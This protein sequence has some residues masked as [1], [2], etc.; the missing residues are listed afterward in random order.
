MGNE[1]PRAAS[2]Q[3]RTE[4][5]DLVAPEAPSNLSVVADEV[6]IGRITVR[7]SPVAQDVD[8]GELTGLAGYIVYRSEGSNS[9]FVPIN[10]VGADTREYV[11]TGLQALTTY[12][13]RVL[14]FDEAGNESSVSNTA[15]TQT[16]GVPVP[17]NLIAVAAIGRIELRWNAVDDEDLLGYNL[18]RSSRSD[19]GYVLLSGDEGVEFTTGQTAYIDSN[20]AAGAQFFY[21]VQAVAGADQLSDCLLYTSDAADE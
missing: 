1:G 3:V 16:L 17:V 9:S 8:G 21:K 10:S 18:F 13:Y 6:D 11:D 5:P 7:W 15:Q 2:V 4:G 19:E 14:A 20:L 12:A